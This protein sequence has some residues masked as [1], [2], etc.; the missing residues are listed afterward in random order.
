[1]TRDFGQ[2]DLARR[3]LGLSG[4]APV[5]SRVKSLASGETPLEQIVLD[6]AQR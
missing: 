2:S 3:G 6:P 1:M 4:D 5:L